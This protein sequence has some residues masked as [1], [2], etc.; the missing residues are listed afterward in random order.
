MDS[1]SIAFGLVPLAIGISILL[2]S[3]IVKDPARSTLVKMFCWPKPYQDRKQLV[4]TGLF[5]IALGGLVFLSATS[6]SIYLLVLLIVV[7]LGLG[8]AARL[9]QPA[10]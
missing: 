4:L 1:A 3:V 2:T 5:F 9:R 10:V 8:V 7:I 6:A